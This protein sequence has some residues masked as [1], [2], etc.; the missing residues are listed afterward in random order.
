MQYNN[1]NVAGLI[2]EYGSRKYQRR[3]D[4]IQKETLLPKRL[5]I[6][7]LLAQNYANFGI[8]A[9]KEKNIRTNIQQKYNYYSQ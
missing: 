8:C 1:E 9:D 7:S 3:I 4:H 5:S 2:I 6:T